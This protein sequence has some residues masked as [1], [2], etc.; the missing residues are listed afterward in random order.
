[1]TH[2]AIVLGASGSLFQALLRSLGFE[3]GSP[4]QQLRHRDGPDELV[5]MRRTGAAA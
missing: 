5:M 2:T 1:M 4:D 3:P